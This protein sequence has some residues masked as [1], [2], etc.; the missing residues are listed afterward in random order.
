MYFPQDI[1]LLVGLEAWP[2]DSAPLF[3]RQVIPGTTSIAQ[4]RDDVG[5]LAKF[6]LLLILETNVLFGTASQV[7][8]NL[9]PYFD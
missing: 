1:G 3:Q 8:L 6:I 4:M 5:I 2:P 7:D 9:K